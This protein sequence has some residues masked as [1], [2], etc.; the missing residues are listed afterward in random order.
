MNKLKLLSEPLNYTFEFQYVQILAKDNKL[1]FE[2]AGKAQG[3]FY[4]KN[5]LY[6]FMVLI[7]S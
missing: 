6:S 2:D 3:L 7:K 4:S 5:L 1:N